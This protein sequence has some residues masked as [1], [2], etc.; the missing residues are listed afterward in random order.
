M[1]LL[2]GLLLTV[3]AGATP[4]AAAEGDRVTAVEFSEDGVTWQSGPPGTIVPPV[5]NPVIPGMSWT[6]SM[7]LRADV[8]MPVNLTWW[9][10]GYTTKPLFMNNDFYFDLRVNGGDWIR[11]TPDLANDRLFAE[12]ELLSGNQ[13][14]VIEFRLTFNWESVAMDFRLDY[15]FDFDV[16]EGASRRSPAPAR[17]R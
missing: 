7:Y 5:V 6:G 4:A 13:A 8:A 2:I 17:W 15:S 16:L 11:L 9:V 14:N 12:S 1:T 3:F 10:P